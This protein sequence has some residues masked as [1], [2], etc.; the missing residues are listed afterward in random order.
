MIFLIM[1]TLSAS[2]SQTA[3]D[4]LKTDMI[5]SAKT[6]ETYNFNLESNQ[7]IVITNHSASATN[8]TNVVIASIGNG[9]VNLTGE[10]MSVTSTMNVISDSAKNVTPV[11]T[12]TYFINDTIY[13]RVDNNWTRLQV[14]NA[15][16]LWGQQNMVLQQSDLL[17]ASRMTMAGS[18]TV[19]GQDCYKVTVVPDINVYAAILSQQMGSSLPLADM[20][21][22]ELFKNSTVEWTSWITRDTNHL[23]KNDIKMAFTITPEIMGI[24]PVGANFEMKVNL[25]AKMLFRDFDKP[26]NITLPDNATN[27]PTLTLIESNTT[28]AIN[29]SKTEVINETKAAAEAGSSTN[30]TAFPLIGG[31]GEITA[32][33]FGVKYSDHTPISPN[34]SP[35]TK[36]LVT[37][38]IACDLPW[39]NA[40]LVDNDDNFYNME[41]SITVLSKFSPIYNYHYISSHIL[42]PCFLIR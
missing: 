16:Q 26:M 25:Q 22:T 19:N 31:N 12:E 24:S 28:S 8:T 4:K 41:Y 5:N 10:E 9:S 23:A 39:F 1:T 13:S 32:T 21:L 29:E 40:V 18:E 42:Y 36:T 20:N 6:L 17:N 14:P 35:E 30:L 7:N 3:E 33:V 11:R 15:S 34:P 38:D 27:A 37:I 2:G